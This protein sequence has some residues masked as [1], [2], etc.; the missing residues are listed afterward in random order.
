MIRICSNH[1]NLPLFIINTFL[2]FWT[3]CTLRNIA[4]S[5]EDKLL[6]S[7]DIFWGIK[8][9]GHNFGIVT[10][11][12]LN[13]FLR[14]PDTWHYHNYICRSAKLGDV[15]NA[16]NDLQGNGAIPSQ[17][18]HQLRIFRGSQ[19]EDTWLHSIPSRIYATC[20]VMAHKVRWFKVRT[21][22]TT[23]QEGVIQIIST[24]VLQV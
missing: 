19:T 7:S 21:Q 14:G 3:M 8:E 23:C 2:S 18:G 16:I 12:E 4:Y 11:F 17:H 20:L 22:S 24:T 9:A 6:V 5:S 1:H 10:S 13:I 15:F